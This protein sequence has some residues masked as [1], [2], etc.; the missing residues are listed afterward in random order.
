MIRSAVGFIRYKEALE[1]D[2]QSEDED[3][4]LAACQPQLPGAALHTPPSDPG[5]GIAGPSTLSSV[6]QELAKYEAEL[7]KLEE[8]VRLLREEVSVCERSGTIPSDV[9]TQGP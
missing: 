2:S 5:Y 4:L 1:N 7:K 9:G 3:L 6:N 8:E